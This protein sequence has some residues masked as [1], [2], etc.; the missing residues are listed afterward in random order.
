[1]ALSLQAQLGMLLAWT[2]V[3]DLFVGLKEE[4]RARIASQL[5]KSGVV[6][7]LLTW[8]FDMFLADKRRMPATLAAQLR[9]PE[10]VLGS[11]AKAAVELDASGSSSFSDARLRL[12]AAALYASMLRRLPALVR[13]YWQ[14]DCPRRLNQAVADFTSTYVSPALIEKELLEANNALMESTSS[15][16]TVRARPATGELVAELLIDEKKME[17][18]IAPSPQHPLRNVEVS[19]GRQRMGVSADQWNRWTMQ[20]VSYIA[21]ENGS[22]LDA[23][24]LWKK[25]VDKKF[26]GVEEC[27]VCYSVIHSSNYQT[28][29]TVSLIGWT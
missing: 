2:L 26:E 8:L 3:T 17:V 20:M 12:L 6:A 24:K 21:N 29:N 10:A 4:E 15:T 7:S 11:L 13:T 23:V 22:L 9:E 5:T 28:P 27:P 1:M 19:T 25:N 18:V 16:M 14:F